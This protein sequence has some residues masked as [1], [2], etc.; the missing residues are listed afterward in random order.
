MGVEVQVSARSDL[1]VRDV[2]HL[3]NSLQE[4]EIEVGVIVLPSDLLQTYLPDRT[5]GLRDAFRIIES[6]FQEAT[7][8]PIAVIAV[9]HDGSSDT[10]LPKQRRNA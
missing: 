10:P 1:I 9:E 8:Y 3:R 5:P 7:T 2:V 4:G 6:E